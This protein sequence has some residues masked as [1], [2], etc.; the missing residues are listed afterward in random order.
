MPQGAISFFLNKNINSESA[1]FKESPC[2]R[3]FC[4]CLELLAELIL[5]VLAKYEK[6]EKYFRF[7]LGRIGFFLIFTSSK[8]A[9]GNEVDFT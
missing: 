1:F 3:D 8:L 7:P 6:Q 2:Y 5:C 9:D 4:L